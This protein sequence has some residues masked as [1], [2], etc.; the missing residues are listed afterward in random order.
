MEHHPI[1][2]WHASRVGLIQ[3]N[4]TQ[5]TKEKHKAGEHIK[6]HLLALISQKWI[7]SISQTSLDETEK[8]LIILKIKC[9]LILTNNLLDMTEKTVPVNAD[10]WMR[11]PRR[12][13][14]R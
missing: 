12:Y 5:T 10:T 14:A 8:L 3:D 9:S 2:L 13:I 7:Y 1:E 6:E 11:A 4:E